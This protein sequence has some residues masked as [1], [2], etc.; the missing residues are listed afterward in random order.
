MLTG[1]FPAELV[2]RKMR[3]GLPLY[4]LMFSRTQSTTSP[5][6]L[7]GSSHASPPPFNPPRRCMFTPVMP[8]FNAH[9]MMLS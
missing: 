9:S 8:F 1:P 3:F 5:T 2:Q 4:F 6:S 7:A